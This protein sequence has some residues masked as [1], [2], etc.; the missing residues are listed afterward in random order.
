LL[1]DWLGA[2]P[3]DMPDILQKDFTR[4]PLIKNA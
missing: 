1:K 4:L 2:K 3:S